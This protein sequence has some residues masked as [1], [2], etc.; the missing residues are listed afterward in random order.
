MSFV[1]AKDYPTHRFSYIDEVAKNRDGLMKRYGVSKKHYH[2]FLFY[3]DAKPQNEFDRGLKDDV[4]RAHELIR[5]SNRTLFEFVK[6]KKAKDPSMGSFL[7]YYT[8]EVETRLMSAVI[9]YCWKHT[10]LFED[11]VT[12]NKIFAYEYDGIKVLRRNVKDVDQTLDQL[13]SFVRDEL[14]FKGVEFVNKPMEKAFDLSDDDMEKGREYLK[15]LLIVPEELAEMG[16]LFGKMDKTVA[17]LLDKYYKGCVAH[18]FNTWYFFDGVRWIRS[19]KS[20]HKLIKML[21]EMLLPPLQDVLKRYANLRP[22]PMAIPTPPQQAYLAVHQELEHLSDRLHFT[23]ELRYI[24]EYLRSYYNDE[25]IQFDRKPFLLGFN[26]GVYDLETDEFREHRYE[27]YLTMSVGYDFVTQRNPQLEKEVSDVLGKVQTD[28]DMRT[29][30]LVVLA[31]GLC[32]LCVESFHIFN[33]NGRNGKGFVDEFTIRTLGDDYSYYAEPTLVTK[34]MNS[35]AGPNPQVANISK[36]RM[37]ILKE[38]EPGARIT[39]FYKSLTGGGRL[40]ARKCHSNDT[41]VYQDLTL[42]IECNSRPLFKESPQMADEIRI[43]DILFDSNFISDVDDYDKKLFVPDT[44]LKT[45]QWQDAHRMSFMW[46]L[47]D[48]F[49]LFREANYRIDVLVPQAVKVR[50][51]QY[52]E[53]NNPISAVFDMAVIKREGYELQLSVLTR[54]L[55]FIAKEQG[56][57]D[58]QCRQITREAVVRWLKFNHHCYD[59]DA[60]ELKGYKLND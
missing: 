44:T 57:T 32:G 11:P 46:I 39:S 19:E 21:P 3:E 52:L 30:L 16:S 43:K 60:Q 15:Q 59:E 55:K 12:G 10:T 25:A 37:I 13:N 56:F 58:I 51:K 26:N 54:Q 45:T 23:K 14:G 2:V 9:E 35:S 34:E 28:G 20:P 50:S 33:G 17:L 5:K 4:A 24:I 7:S 36:K 31:T 29:F 6:R 47:L 1:L 38:P 42:C 41:T 8:Q 53:Q 40:N 27:D 48:H 22:P 18:Q 49:K